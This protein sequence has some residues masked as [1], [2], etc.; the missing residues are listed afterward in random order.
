MAGLALGSGLSRIFSMINDNMDIT[1]SVVPLI[2]QT[3]SVV[4]DDRIERKLS[5]THGRQK[6]ITEEGKIPG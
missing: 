1:L 6:E 5:D 4:P 3:L 2:K